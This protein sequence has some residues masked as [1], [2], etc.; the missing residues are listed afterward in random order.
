MQRRQ[1]LSILRLKKELTYWA[2]TCALELGIRVW[3]NL[4]TSGPYLKGYMYVTSQTE[5][6]EY[7]LGF[8]FALKLL[9]RLINMQCI[10]HSLKQWNKRIHRHAQTKQFWLA[11]SF[12]GG[13]CSASAQARLHAFAERIKSCIGLIRQVATRACSLNQ[14]TASAENW[15]NRKHPYLNIDNARQP[16]IEQ[17]ICCLEQDWVYCRHKHQRKLVT[18]VTW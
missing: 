18:S 15:F 11:F 12:A 3:S 17:W 1:K 7:L 4:C 14:R 9:H 10:R 5:Y 16:T 8:K 13:Y 2:V 6:S